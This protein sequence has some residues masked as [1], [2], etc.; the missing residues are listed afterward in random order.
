MNIS[1]LYIENI[2]SFTGNHEIPFQKLF[3]FDDNIV[4]T[5]KTGSGKSTILDCI[6]LALYGRTYK[7]SLNSADFVSLNCSKG[8][9]VLEFQNY[10]DNYIATWTCQVLKKD[11]SIK[12]QITPKKS[13]LKNG[14][15]CE[16]SIESIINL[17]YEQFSK[18][19]ILNQGQ[20]SKF[21][22]SGYAERKTILERLYGNKE[23]AL[24]SKHLRANYNSTAIQIENINSINKELHEHD[25]ESVKEN[26]QRLKD[27]NLITEKSLQKLNKT[28]NYFDNINNSF[29][30]TVK[31]LDFLLKSNQR[32]AKAEEELKTTTSKYNILQETIAQN[33]N[34][35]QSL[36]KQYNVR[37]PELTTLKEIKIK[38]EKDQ[39]KLTETYNQL[40]VKDEILKKTEDKISNLSSKLKSLK[41][42]IDD[43]NSKLKGISI[44]ECNE[45][46]AIV[47]ELIKNDIL[48]D[49]KT[50]QIQ[51]LTNKKETIEIDR[52]KFLKKISLNKNTLQEFFHKYSIN[53]DSDQYEKALTDFINNINKMSELNNSLIK[54][55]QKSV[56]L[57][58]TLME[59]ENNK[60]DTNQKCEQL[61]I[62]LKKNNL[63]Y[64]KYLCLT[65]TDDHQSCPLCG[66]TNKIDQIKLKQ[67]D[68]KNIKIIEQNYNNE[69]NKLIKFSAEH[70]NIIKQLN[71]LIFILEDEDTE[72][73]KYYKKYKFESNSISQITNEYL[74]AIIKESK[75]QTQLIFN[76]KIDRNNL[77]NIEKNIKNTTEDLTKIIREK[78]D[79]DK[80]SSNFIFNYNNNK[81]QKQA[82]VSSLEKIEKILK[83]YISSFEKKSNLEHEVKILN[84][85]FND[86]L[87]NKE[88][89]KV[90]VDNLNQEAENLKKQINL[91][92]IKFNS[93][94]KTNIDPDLEIKQFEKDIKEIKE[95]L[96]SLSIT[97][98]DLQSKTINNQSTISL[99]LLQNKEI[100]LSLI[101]YKQI[102]LTN[103]DKIDL[104]D[105][106]INNNISTE[107]FYSFFKKYNNI[108]H[109]K[110]IISIKDEISNFIV[111]YLEPVH[112]NIMNTITKL[113][114]LEVENKTLLTFQNELCNKI[115]NNLSKIKKLNSS[116]RKTDA[117]IQLI[118]N[119]Q[120]RNFVLDYLQNELVNKTNQELQNLCDSR[121]ELLQV[122]NNK[123]TDFYI[124]DFWNN[125][126]IRKVSTLSGGETFLVSLAMA[127]SLADLFKGKANLNSF[128]IDEG[129]GHLD[130]EH[131]D[132]AYEIL[133]KVASTG[134]KIGIITHVK[135]LSDRFNVKVEIQKYREG[136]KISIS[137]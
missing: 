61:S 54:T 41:S 28:N 1:S 87:T 67:V 116:L 111:K 133:N 25:I 125:S 108:T 134:K 77:A 42:S 64:G 24:I 69:N 93:L 12:K 96:K 57:K 102:I 78:E 21:L 75:T 48:I 2:A 38:I 99:A 94:N 37:L 62:K 59:I 72:L 83:D 91:D 120:F 114:N 118:G 117:T 6:A 123:S 115:E 100:E 81:N 45:Q 55:K 8:K 35:H 7:K 84:S 15:I 22:S 122:K 65:N 90:D 27:E 92:K 14:Q 119:D 89:T 32:I 34:N 129:F 26:I 88:E 20:F 60:K 36:E 5:G 80:I 136:S 106:Q 52:S 137:Y 43:I 53:V 17:D 63:L 74:E 16:E 13:L 132:E 97:K 9:I 135:E 79:L 18:T 40:K 70:D 98:D 109:F 104:E 11:G 130:T 3:N 39:L 113:Q 107:K 76:D 68:I 30:E 56:L 126:K 23:I 4:I 44:T 73:N 29:K 46:Y 49:N 86:I 112:Q 105:L 33:E 124:K 50:S 121:Y 10:S 66:N 58:N 101:S 71:E 103:I 51:E 85:N 131:I 47:K 95:K 110:N 82:N 127:L 19:I 31:Q 128:F